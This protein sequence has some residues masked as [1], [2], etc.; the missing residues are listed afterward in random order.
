MCG[1]TKGIYIVFNMKSFYVMPHSKKE[2]HS[3]IKWLGFIGRMAQYFAD[4]LMEHNELFLGLNNVFNW[5]VM[6]IMILAT[7]K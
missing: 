6:F 5:Y 3:S 7:L 4:G 2:I 1:M